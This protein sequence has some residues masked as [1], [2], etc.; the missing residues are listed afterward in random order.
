MKWKD[1][2]SLLVPTQN[3]EQT[4]ELCLRSFAEFPD[5]MIIVDNGSTDRTKEIVLDTIRELPN[6]RFFDCPE[7]K[8]LYHNRQYAFEHSNFGW[9][10]RIDSDYVAYT[11]GSHNICR[12]RERVLSTPKGLRPVALSVRQLTLFKDIRHIGIPREKRAKGAGKYVQGPLESLPAR[13][14]QRYPGMRFQRNGR[15]EGVRFQKWL[16]HITIDDIYWFHCALKSDR[17]YLFRS[18]RTNWRESGDFKRYPTLESYIREKIRGMY[19]T[20]DIDE[21]AALYVREYIE[22]YLMEYRPEEW[23]PYPD[24][25][26]EI[27]ASGGRL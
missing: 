17:D 5:E 19:G 25:L 14:V 11:S 16:K 3:S 22:P 15:W 21:A 27:L 23:L 7:L 10:M 12:L 13:I 6:A 4:V 8:D 2:I 24:L 26:Q 20:D 1:G 18:E 9:V